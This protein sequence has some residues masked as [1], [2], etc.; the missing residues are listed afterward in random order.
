MP[1]K[2]GISIY[3]SNKCSLLIHRGVKRK[4]QPYSLQIFYFWYPLDSFCF[5]M[6]CGDLQSICPGRMIFD[7][8]TSYPGQLKEISNIILIIPLNIDERQ[9]PLL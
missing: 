7:L 2:F 8:Q 9:E 4:G 3:L 6:P 1:L 5:Q